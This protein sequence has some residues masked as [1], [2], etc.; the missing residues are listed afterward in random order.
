ML[1]NFPSSCLGTLPIPACFHTAGVF[2]AGSRES[3]RVLQAAGPC[4]KTPSMSPSSSDSARRGACTNRWAQAGHRS[5]SCDCGW[6]PAHRRHQLRTC[7]H[8]ECFRRRRRA[9]QPAR[10]TKDS[11]ERNRD[12]ACLTPSGPRSAPPKA[13][14]RT[15]THG[16]GATVPAHTYE[17]A[18]ILSPPHMS[19]SCHRRKRRD[20]HLKHD[21]FYLWHAK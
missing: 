15:R 10:D 12:S 13:P 5:G 20:K 8:R 19:T 7:G 4:S 11:G 9:A 21:S 18:W 1:G 16:P 17:R 14:P 6:C 2:C 3:P